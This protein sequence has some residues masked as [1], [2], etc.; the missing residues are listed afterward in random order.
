MSIVY[1]FACRYGTRSED[2][3]GLGL[4]GQKQGCRFC[5]SRVFL[6]EMGTRF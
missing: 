1:F 3:A 4:V 5:H 6:L 2:G